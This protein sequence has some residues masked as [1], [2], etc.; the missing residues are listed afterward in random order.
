MD[1]L[2]NLEFGWIKYLNLPK[3]PHQNFVLYGV[4]ICSVTV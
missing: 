4:I 3:F 1:A 2:E